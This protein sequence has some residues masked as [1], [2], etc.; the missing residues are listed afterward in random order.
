M[1]LDTIKAIKR[2]TSDNPKTYQKGFDHLMNL[3]IESTTGF[4]ARGARQFEQVLLPRLGE[5][6]GV[7]GSKPVDSEVKTPNWDLG[8][9]SQAIKAPNWNLGQ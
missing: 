4:P 3:A 1:A 6:L 2:L 9:G 8:G 5:G 7:E